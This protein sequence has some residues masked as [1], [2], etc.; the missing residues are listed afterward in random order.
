MSDNYFYISTPEESSIVIDLLIEAIHTDQ[1]PYGYMGGIVMPLPENKQFSDELY[2]RNMKTKHMEFRPVVINRAYCGLCVNLIEGKVEFLCHAL[3]EN[4][5]YFTDESSSIGPGE[6]LPVTYDVNIV[7]AALI[8]F[9]SLW[10]FESEDK[11]PLTC[12]VHPRY[13]N[14][15]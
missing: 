14:N 9:L 4:E 1:Y 6:F 7:K 13:I 10:D 15:R 11:D 2:I 8:R 12:S 5:G 3:N